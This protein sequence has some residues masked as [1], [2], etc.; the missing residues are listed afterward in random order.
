MTIS[1]NVIPSGARNLLSNQEKKQIPRTF[2][3]EKVPLGDGLGM[4][5]NFEMRS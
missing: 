4:T 1:K 3:L 2:A 5:V